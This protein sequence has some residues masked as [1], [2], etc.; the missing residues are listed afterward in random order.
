M[1]D[2]DIDDSGESSEEENGSD[3]D[4]ADQVQENAVPVGEAIVPAQ[5]V[6]SSMSIQLNDPKG[7]KF[8]RMMEKM[9]NSTF[10]SELKVVKKAI[11]GVANTP[12]TLIVHVQ[13]LSGTVALNIP[14]PPT[15][16]IW[17][18]FRNKPN[19]K[20]S[21]KPKFGE[22]TVNLTHVTDWIQAKIEH[23]ASVRL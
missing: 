21:A 5:P 22:R 15:N 4:D 11:A 2:S 3:V 14:P 8:M 6:G 17:F 23:E 16:R 10:V 19:L 13:S 9:A 20:L 12:L 7:G 18:G 1:Y